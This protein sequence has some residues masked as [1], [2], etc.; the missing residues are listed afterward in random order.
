MSQARNPYEIHDYPSRRPTGVGPWTLAFALFGGTIAWTVHLI[1]GYSVANY[2]CGDAVAVWI[3]HGLTVVALTVVALAFLTALRVVRHA[4]R[5]P[6][7]ERTPEE[8][9]DQ[10]LA[11]GGLLLAG[12]GFMAITFGEVAVVVAGCTP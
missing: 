4:T 1:A 10:F 11:S 3:L 8:D 12:L 9:R 5:L 6:K 7:G 2:M